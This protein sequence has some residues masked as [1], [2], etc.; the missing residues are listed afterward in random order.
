M[1]SVYGNRKRKAIIRNRYNYLAPFIPRHIFKGKK[2]ALKVTE[3]QT[4][5][6]KTSNK[7]ENWSLL[8]Q[9]EKWSQTV[10]EAFSSHFF[11]F[12]I[13]IYILKTI[14]LF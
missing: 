6:Y 14:K 5:D 2:D 1:S 11:F 4:I 9:D 13:Y 7:D 3:R 8:L 12:F 10:Q